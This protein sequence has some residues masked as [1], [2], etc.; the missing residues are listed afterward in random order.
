MTELNPLILPQLIRRWTGQDP[1]RDVLTFVEVDDRGEFRDETRSF[2]QLWDNGQRIAWALTE[3]GMAPGDRFA[4]MMQ[5]HP[6]FVDAMVGSGIANTMFVPVDPRARGA[7]LRFMLG[8]AECRGVL[9]TDSVLPQLTDVLAGLPQLRW[10]WVLR[11]G[12]RPTPP[13]QLPGLRAVDQILA[14]SVPD[15]PILARDPAEPMQ[16]LYTSGTTGD[17]KAIITTYGRFGR[18]GSLNGV[19]GLRPDDRPYS[20]LSLSHPNAQVITLGNVLVMGLRGVFSRRFTKSRLWDICRHYGCTEFNLLGGMT[21]AIYSE[22]ERPND[23]DNPVRYVIS[24]GMPASIWPRFQERFGVEIFEFYGTAEG[25]LSFNPPGVAPVGSIGKPP[26]TLVAKVVDGQGEECPPGVTGELVFRNAD[27]TCDPVNYYRDPEASREKTLG[28]WFH[29]G[30]MGHRSADGWLYFGYRSGD[31]IRHNGEFIDPGQV[32]KVIAEHPT[33]DDVF[34]Y[35]IESA[36]GAPGE[37]DVVAAV[38]PRNRAVFDPDALYRHCGLQLDSG[39]VPSYLQ[40]MDEIPKTASEKPLKRLC[41]EALTT[42][43]DRVIARAG[44]ISTRA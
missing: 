43:P 36:G 35:G 18:I 42:Q 32:E 29:S 17:P 30:D 22:P 15:L 33:V 23:A 1:D 16:L 4:I 9:L 10:V 19:I 27:G 21:T 20:G 28:G 25:G 40:V 24:A 14:G 8:F 13:P 44:N 5:N 12:N 39:A 7:K 31:A 11:T 3:A 38:V 26:P 37:R 6:E 2:Q 41:E 34:V